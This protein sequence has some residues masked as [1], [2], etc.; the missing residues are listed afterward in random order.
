MNE[1][2]IKAK[3]IEFHRNHQISSPHSTFGRVG[4]NDGTTICSCG[5]RWHTFYS[6]YGLEWTPLNEQA[7]AHDQAQ[8][9]LPDGYGLDMEG[10]LFK[11]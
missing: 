11:E 9:M 7:T 3:L 10:D 6:R 1:N 8:A 4:T 2:E 5:A